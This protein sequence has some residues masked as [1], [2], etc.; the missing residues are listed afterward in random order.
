MISQVV[1]IMMMEAVDFEVDLVSVAHLVTRRL[2]D[3]SLQPAEQNMPL[4]PPSLIR[5]TP[6]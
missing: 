5:D 3:D 6:L 1:I 4:P 2:Y